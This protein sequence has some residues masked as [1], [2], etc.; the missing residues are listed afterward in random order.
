MPPGVQL[1]FSASSLRVCLPVKALVG[2]NSIGLQ[3]R[4]LL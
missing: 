4:P 2:K 1:A 3:L